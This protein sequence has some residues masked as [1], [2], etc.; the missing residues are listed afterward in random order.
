MLFHPLLLPG[1]LV[2]VFLLTFTLVLPFGLEVGDLGVDIKDLHLPLPLPR[3][4]PLPLDPLP[5]LLEAPRGI[6]DALDL[7]AALPLELSI[8]EDL[9]F[10]VIVRLL[11]LGV[12]PLEVKPLPL[13]RPLPLPLPL[14]LP[15]PLVATLGL[16]GASAELWL[17]SLSFFILFFSVSN[18]S[19]LNLV[20]LTYFS[21]LFLHLLHSQRA[22]YISNLIKPKQF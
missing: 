16:G 5:L 8:G 20:T 2:G 1:F 10:E 21:T 13:P 11:K 22:G 19:G 4:P 18:K 3:L 9:T 17:L 6:T 15:R 7:E 12:L 14:P